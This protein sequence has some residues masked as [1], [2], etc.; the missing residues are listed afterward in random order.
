LDPTPKGAPSTTAAEDAE[1]IRAAQKGDRQA[2]HRLVDLYHGSLF[3]LVV[4][5]TRSRMDAE[6]IVQE[7]FLKAYDKLGRLKQGT[8]FRSWLYQIALN[9]VRDHYRR[10]KV[11]AIFGSLEEIP[12]HDLPAAA[13]THADGY[14]RV[15][16]KRFW[17]DFYRMLDGL[18][19]W[20]ER[21]LYCAFLMS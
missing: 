19:R 8:A 15:A 2:F 5:R 17:A 14:E 3:R 16:R 18:A 10:N 1:L 21:C 13:Q 7:V 11:R 12:E 9:K 4:V 6:D 20:R